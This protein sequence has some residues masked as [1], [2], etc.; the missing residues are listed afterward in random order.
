MTDS[1]YNRVKTTLGAVTPGTR[2]RIPGKFNGKTKLD[3]R[4]LHDCEKMNEKCK[5][6]SAEFYIDS[7][8]EERFRSRLINTTAS[9]EFGSCN[10]M[11][12][13]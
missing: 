6:D 8:C 9:C 1:G 12:Y 4:L 7:D 10:L 3:R 5:E 2:F 13:R 11:V